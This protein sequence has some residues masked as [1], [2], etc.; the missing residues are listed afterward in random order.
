MSFLASTTNNSTGVETSRGQFSGQL[1]WLDHNW[2]NKIRLWLPN[3]VGALTRIGSGTNYGNAHY[4]VGQHT[5]AIMVDH[6][7]RALRQAITAPLEAPTVVAGGGTTPQIAYLRFFDEIT[8]ERSPL[9]TGTEFT[10]N[11]SRTWTSLPTEVPGEQ[12]IL[13]GTATFAAG[14]V[15]GDGKTNF[16]ELRPG[17]RIAVSTAT[18]RW[19]KVRSIAS[20]ISMVVDDTGMAGAGVT[21]VA[22]TVSR[23]SHVEL[24]LSVNGSLPRFVMRV[25]IGTTSVS[26]ATATLALG[27]AETKSFTALPY[28]SMNCFYNDRQFISGFECHPDTIYAS[29][30]EFPE[31]HEGLIFRTPYGEPVV[32][33]IRYRDYMIVLCPDSSYKIQGYSEDDY[34]RTVLDSNIGGLGHRGNIVTDRFAVV[35]G[36]K[37]VMVFNGA[38][39]PSIPTRRSEWGDNYIASKRAFEEGFGAV[40]PNDETYQ[41]YP[42][43]T[44][45]PQ[46]S[47]SSVFVG[48]YTSVESA[49][50][51]SVSAIEWTTDSHYLPLP[52]NFGGYTTFAAYLSIAGNRIGKFYRGSNDGDIWEEDTAGTVAFHLDSYVVPAHYLFG[53]PG[54]SRDLE[55]HKLK[56]VFHYVRSEQSAWKYE[57]WPG[58]EYAYP[59]D[60]DAPNQANLADPTFS[61]GFI[62]T[63]HTKLIG[64]DDA[65]MSA[66]VTHESKPD[67]DG[68]G[69]TNAYVFTAP[70]NVVFV[71]F[72]MEIAPGKD[73]RPI[74]TLTQGG[75]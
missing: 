21:L 16:G 70:L 17:D 53:D 71:G 24:W 51:G 38:F 13:E 25:R 33:L 32:G 40:N 35:P 47:P 65:T 30:I 15:T 67:K 9:S 48:D 49:A 18:T 55:G 61:D 64:T 63:L 4:L 46:F 10:G 23:V 31:R 22:K 3:S 34:T 19:T 14:T 74:H 50:G 6:Q 11:T 42:F 27:E 72:T 1:W 59:Q 28:G 12:V 52:A 60:I 36:R 57:C 68:R 44:A 75:T 37:G 20:Q 45:L 54:G 2:S 73:S 5:A 39:H 66:K 43:F 29:A 69:F 62:A 58:D 41:F 8:S 56:R 26:E 7:L